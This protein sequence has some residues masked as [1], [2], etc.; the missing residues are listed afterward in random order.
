MFHT[1]QPGHADAVPESLLRDAVLSARSRT[2]GER[3]RPRVSGPSRTLKNL[4]QEQGV[5]A[6]LRDG[7]LL[8]VGDVLLF[9]PYLGANRGAGLEPAAGPC[10]RIEW[11]PDLQPA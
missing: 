11:R 9:A 6:W 8:F 4:Y 10:R 2:G 7:P 5:P 3:L 1:A